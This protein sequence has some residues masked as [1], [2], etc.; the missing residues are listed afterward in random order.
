[1]VKSQQK[2]ISDFR[3]GVDRWVDWSGVQ[4]FQCEQITEEPF[5]INN[6]HVV[7]PKEVSSA[8]VDV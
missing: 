3:V 7:K 4:P 1:M 2:G 8:D 5:L 6:A